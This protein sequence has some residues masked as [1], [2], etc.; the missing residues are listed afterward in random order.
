MNQNLLQLL[1]CTADENPISWP[2]RLPTVMFAYRMTVH[3]VTGLTPN[4]AMFGREVMLPTSLVA[5][6]PVT[7]S[8]PFVLELRDA[9]R[10]AHE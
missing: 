1:R 8:V 6:P 9:L 4:M 3:K 5:K 10:N 7:S 2:Q